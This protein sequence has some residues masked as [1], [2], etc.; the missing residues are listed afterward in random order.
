MGNYLNRGYKMIYASFNPK[1]WKILL[2]AMITTGLKEK[3][4]TFFTSDFYKLVIADFLNEDI[5]IKI[6]QFIEQWENEHRKTTEKAIECTKSLVD[7]EFI[8]M[9]NLSG[10]HSLNVSK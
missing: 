6:N 2:C 7:N 10:K 4:Y 1:C 9:F 5:K 8:K 3:D